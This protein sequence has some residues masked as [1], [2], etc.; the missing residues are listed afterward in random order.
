MM[1]FGIPWNWNSNNGIVI[2][3]QTTLNIHLGMDMAN[4]LTYDP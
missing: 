1:E 2:V 4:I 3:Y